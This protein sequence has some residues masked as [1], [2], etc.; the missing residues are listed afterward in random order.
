[1]TLLIIIVL[2]IVLFGGGGYYYNSGQY[3]GGGIGIGAILVIGLVVLYL[4]GNLNLH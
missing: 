1:M 3:R 4:T 2:L